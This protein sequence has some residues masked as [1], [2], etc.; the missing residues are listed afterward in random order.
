MEGKWED[1]VMYPYVTRVVEVALTG[2]H[3]IK[4]VG[5][6]ERILPILSYCRG[7][8]LFCKCLEP[9]G[10]GFYKDEDEPCSCDTTTIKHYQNIIRSFVCDITVEVPRTYVENVIDILTGKTSYELESK[11]FERIKLAQLRE[12]PD[13]I[14]DDSIKLLKTA[15]KRFY[16]EPYQIKNII[17]LSYTIAKLENSKVVEARHMAEAIQYNSYKPEII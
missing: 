2:K 6:Y 5:R 16:F 4:F 3:S 11:V 13:T 7:A 1:I 8:G 17:N 10:C 9:C 14:D 12:Q 15:A